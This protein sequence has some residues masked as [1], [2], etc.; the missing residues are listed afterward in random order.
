M[1]NNQDS[2]DKT[3]RATPKRL[4]DARKRGDIAKSKDVTSTLGLAFTLV[5]MW[6]ILTHSMERLA[7]LFEHA[8]SMNTMPFDQLLVSVGTDAINV[9]L[10][11]TALFLLP[12]AAFGMLVEFLQTGPIFAPDKVRP[13]L[14]KLNAAEGVKRMFSMDNF[15]E[16]IKSIGKTAI[17]G[18]T[19]YLV[20][21][22]QVQQIVLLPAATSAHVVAAASTIALQMLAWTLGIFLIIMAMDA[23]YQRHSYA[24][25][26]KM[27][28]RDIRQEHKNNEGDPMMKGQRK[29]MHKEWSQQGATQAAR[30]ATVVVVNPTHVAIAILFDKEDTP[31]PIVT[32]KGEDDTARSMRE[33]ANELNIPVLRNELLART[34]LADVDE[35]DHIPRG[36]FDIVAEVILWATRTSDS[37]ARQRG[38]IP[39][40]TNTAPVPDAPGEDLTSYPP[41]MDVFN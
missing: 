15:F 16:V 2:G 9:F 38:D 35:G 21:Q 24:K 18:I 10:S 23:A 39:A 30:S 4:R 11:L 37:V 27:S 36:L 25:K 40:Q 19:A 1:E 6:L 14:E 17:L 29:R 8:M 41:G 5:L 34:L 28:L 7:S 12:V 33:A 31:V 3:E 26:M 13:S 32:A 22:T 20:I